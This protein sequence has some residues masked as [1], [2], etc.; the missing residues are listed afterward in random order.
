MSRLILY[1]TPP[2]VSKHSTTDSASSSC[3]ACFAKSRKLK[4]SRAPG[5][6]TGG[7]TGSHGRPL[8]L[9]IGGRLA[10]RV[11]P[12]TGAGDL[13]S[14]GDPGTGK[15]AAISQTSGRSNLPP[16]G[17]AELQLPPH[18]RQ[19]IGRFPRLGSEAAAAPPSRLMNSR[20]FI[21]RCLPRLRQKASTPQYG[22]RPM[23]RRKT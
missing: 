9:W 2:S 23:D 20:R 17:L 8:I 14:P 21:A 10:G 13:E 7:I 1:F 18:D 12:F 4:L 3:A 16:A 19:R 15:P 22:M 6:K 5:G 11:R